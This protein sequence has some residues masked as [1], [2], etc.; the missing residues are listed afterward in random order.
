VLT[1]AV[2]GFEVSKGVTSGSSFEISEGK[3][4]LVR[5]MDEKVSSAFFDLGAHLTRDLISGYG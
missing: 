3:L 2:V 5:G 4:R 1:L